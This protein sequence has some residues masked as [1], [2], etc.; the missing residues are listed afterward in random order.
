MSLAAVGCV[1]AAAAGA[2]AAGALSDPPERRLGGVL[3]TGS[4]SGGARDGAHGGRR[5]GSSDASRT[6]TSRV[7][8]G[9][10]LLLVA[11]LVPG[12]LGLLL[13]VPVAVS[14]HRFLEGLPD[15][16]V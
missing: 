1:L 6:W 2:G 8:A 13:A 10:L 16:R 15:Q 14:G 5:T 4:E 7:L 12:V 11:S 3:S 9:S